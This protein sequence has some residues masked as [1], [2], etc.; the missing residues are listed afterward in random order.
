MRCVGLLKRRHIREPCLRGRGNTAGSFASTAPPSST[1]QKPSALSRMTDDPSLEEWGI[2]LVVLLN[3]APDV[4]GKEIA[5]T[6]NLQNR[7]ETRD[8]VAQD[9]GKKGLREEMAI[10]GVNYQFV[11]SEQSNVGA[12]S[13]EL[14]E[15]TLALACASRDCGLAVQSSRHLPFGS[16]QTWVNRPT[17]LS[18]TPHTGTRLSAR[19]ARTFCIQDG[20]SLQ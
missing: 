1:A 9:S 11:R 19:K 16:V 6:D 18:S 14:V 17:R 2:D 4:F 15:V 3:A 10:E 20:R 7:I 12:T 13:C 8:F 5:R